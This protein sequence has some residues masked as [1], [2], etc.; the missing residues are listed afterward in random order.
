MSSIRGLA[1]WAREVGRW[2]AAR[3]GV[4]SE[5]GGTAVEYGVMVSLIAAVTI[6]AVIFLGK[7]TSS[8]FSCVASNVGA[9][10]NATEC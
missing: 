1:S 4:E 3:V 2:V 7:K 10:F 8:S 9:G 6:V 5:R